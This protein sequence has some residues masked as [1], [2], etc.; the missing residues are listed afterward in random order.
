[1]IEK[2]KPLNVYSVSVA[3]QDR[4]SIYVQSGTLAAATKDRARDMAVQQMA[5]QQPDIRPKDLIVNVSEIPKDKFR[6]YF[7]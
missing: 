4:R 6:R 5:I 2:I 7:K 3:W 1:M